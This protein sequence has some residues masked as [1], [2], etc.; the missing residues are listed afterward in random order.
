MIVLVSCRVRAK[1][2]EDQ[3][4]AGLMRGGLYAEK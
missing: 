3:R 1:I 4:R 2:R